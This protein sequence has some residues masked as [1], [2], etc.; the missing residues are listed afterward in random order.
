MMQDALLARVFSKGAGDFLQ[1]QCRLRLV[2]HDGLS[3]P[4]GQLLLNPGCKGT[5]DQPVD[6]KG[7]FCILDSFGVLAEFVEG[8]TRIE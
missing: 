3:P 5:F 8:Q 1:G 7:N 4:F 2:V 6:F